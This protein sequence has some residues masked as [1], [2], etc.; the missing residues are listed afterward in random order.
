MVTISA[1]QAGKV[2]GTFVPVDPNTFPAAGQV[3]EVRLQTSII[4]V[5]VVDQIVGGI[6]FLQTQFSTDGFEVLWYEVGNDYIHY[7]YRI[8]NPAIQFSFA[9]LVGPILTLLSL[10]LIFVIVW[11]VG[12]IISPPGFQFAIPIAILLV[13]SAL[14]IGSLRGIKLGDILKRKK[15]S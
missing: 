12:M 9:S 4:P 2:G 3:Y 11:Q 15:K 7:Q 10:L 5:G 13:A 1:F 14:V 6:L 8:Q